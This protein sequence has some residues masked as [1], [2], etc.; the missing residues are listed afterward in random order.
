LRAALVQPRLS[1]QLWRITGLYDD[2]AYTASASSHDSA[3]EMLRKFTRAV[4]GFKPD[5]R[6]GLV[7]EKARF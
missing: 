2:L 6:K 4:S 1:E 3:A 5:R 7:K